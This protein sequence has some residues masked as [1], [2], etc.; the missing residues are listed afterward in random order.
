MGMGS[1]L[2]SESGPTFVVKIGGALLGDADALAALWPSARM[3]Y[4]ARWVFVHGG[5]PQSTEMA[6]R[7]GHEPRMVAGRRVTT[8]LDLDI[9]LWTLNGSL[10]ARLVASAQAAGLRAVGISAADGGT[11]VVEKRAPREIDGELVDFGHVG[12]VA[13]ADST[14]LR[15]LQDAAFTLIVAPICGDGRGNLFNVNADTVAVEIAVATGAEE[16]LMVA[17]AGAVFRDFPN[18]ESRLASIDR[19]TFAEGV[20][21]GWISDGMRPKLETAFDAHARGIAR[22]RIC[23]PGDL[24]DQHAGT[25]IS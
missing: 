24:A 6:R 23:G 16:L 2:R 7:L 9:S 4:H 20:A 21:A 19:E 18:P 13:R 12:D 11:V 15:S 5:G 25:L 10:N 22:V 8:D 1:Q 3:N 17:E 14:L